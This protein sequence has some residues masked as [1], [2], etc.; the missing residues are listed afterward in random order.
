MRSLILLAML[1]ASAVAPPLRP[2]IIAHRGASGHRP[3]HTL[4]AYRLAVE[5]GADFIEPDLV[6]TKDGVLIARHENEI[7]GTTNVADRFP[8][9]KRTKTIDGQSMT[10]WFTEDFTLSEIK[11]LRARERLPFRSHAY[12]GQF[13]IV[14]FDE[15]IELA[16]QLGVAYVVEGSVRK[17]GDRVR[18]TAQLIDA[19]TDRH[20]WARSYERDLRDVLTLQGEVAASIA[21]E[22]RVRIEPQVKARLAREKR[23]DPRAYEA[24]LRGRHHWNRRT[25]D[26]VRRG[27]EYFQEAIDRDPAYAPA[28]AGLAQAYD[29]QGSYNFLPPGEA[30]SLARAAVSRALELDESL[31][32]AHVAWG[33]VLQSHLWDWAG[34]EAE[35]R[36][37]LELDPNLAGAHHWYADFLTGMGR[38]DEAITSAR[39]AAELDPL[40]LAINMTLGA[41]YFYARRYEE[42]MEQQ[43]KTL[44][45]DP[46]F[47]PAHRSM[48]GAL[49]QLGRYDEAIVE[50]RKGAALSDDLSATSLLAHALAVS[51]NTEEAW[52]ILEDLEEAAARDQYV[53]PYSLAAV[54][55]GLGN[56]DRAF[57]LLNRAYHSRDRGMASLW[58]APRFDP[59]RAD[60]R[61]T[62][63]LRRMNFP[64]VS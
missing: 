53:S 9:R 35:F 13:Q 25:A 60:P 8:D 28:Y 20:L 22:I 18:I 59:L 36:R 26:G 46:S 14:T 50:F 5:M 34:A 57:E 42:A 24:Y 30:F 7:G 44:D 40:N 1:F 54:Y 12:D 43:R 39:R 2:L 3:E 17:S 27:I 52:R 64:G 55:T 45:L 32:E 63:L 47:A 56:T 33:G 61:F 10:G 23:V 6:S 62:D 11:T 19:A 51:G 21:G 38:T 41:A 15:V 48:G 58:V 4:E 31:P 29:T 16:Q 37:A 49:E